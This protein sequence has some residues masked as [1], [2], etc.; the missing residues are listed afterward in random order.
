VT[1]SDSSE[2]VT[3]EQVTKFNPANIYITGSVGNGSS[4]EYTFSYDGQPIDPFDI[5]FRVYDNTECHAILLNLDNNK[6]RYD[7]RCTM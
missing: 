1:V 4:F 5:G 3:I 6:D 2:L 7:I